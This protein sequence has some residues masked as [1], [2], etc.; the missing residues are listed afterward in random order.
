MLRGTLGQCF[1]TLSQVP[2]RNLTRVPRD[3]WFGTAA[4]KCKCTDKAM[5]A[6]LGQGLRGFSTYDMYDRAASARG[7]ETTFL[8]C[9]APPCA[10]APSYES[11]EITRF[12]NLLGKG[13]RVQRW[14]PC[15][16]SLASERQPR[17]LA[18]EPRHA[19]SR[20]Q[21]ACARRATDSHDEAHG[22][23]SE[24][25]FQACWP[26]ARKWPAALA[27]GGSRSLACHVC[28]VRMW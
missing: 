20:M 22:L 3:P 16:R 19:C 8:G 13:S 17:R 7:E 10:S 11:T 18:H 27:S 4:P 21:H 5:T 25:T 26:A 2:V 9:R 14:R 24:R 6:P 12:S 23:R 28:G 1:K 15:P